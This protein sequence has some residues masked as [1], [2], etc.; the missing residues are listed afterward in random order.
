MDLRRQ[1]R[2]GAHYRVIVRHAGFAG[3]GQTENLSERGAMLSLDLDTGLTPG[4][5]VELEIDLPQV[6][7]IQLTATVRWVSA[8][9][10]GINGVEFCAP[11][12]PE[13]LAHIASLLAAEPSSATG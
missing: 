12:A 7:R 9:L 2:V 3:H 13:L 1:P 8:V 4:D 11:V 10:P 5:R 6:G